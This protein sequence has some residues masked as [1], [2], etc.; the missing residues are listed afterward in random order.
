MDDFK[1]KIYIR[2]DTVQEET[3]WYWIVDDSGSW[4]GPKNEWITSHYDKYFKYLK[5]R[6]VVITAGANCGMYA[7]LY[8]KQ[9]K[10]VYAFEPTPL[11]FHCMVMNNQ[12]T[13]VI[14]FNCALGDKVRMIGMYETNT[15]NSGM[16]E[17]R[18]ENDDLSH[19]FVKQEG[20]KL[21]DIIIP[22]L[23][24]DTLQLP[25]CDLIQLDVQGYELECLKGGKDTIEKFKPVII[26]EYGNNDEKI[27][28]YLK[29]INYIHK[30][31]SGID[32]IFL[33]EKPNS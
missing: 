22:R 17:A 27:V 30:D 32:D 26:L 33:Y 12:N 21:T 3:G 25:E 4:D 20:T 14:K 31:R 19:S 6:N 15:T 1:D 7:K 16:N 28:N 2:P 9:F 5:N 13:N 10:A 18:I 23:T 24:I 11:N 29:T 8:S